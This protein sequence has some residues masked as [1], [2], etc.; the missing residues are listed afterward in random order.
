MQDGAPGDL[1]RVGL[2][3]GQAATGAAMETGDQ[4][5]LDRMDFLLQNKFERISCS[6]K[7]ISR[8]NDLA[9][10]AAPQLALLDEEAV[11]ALHAGCRVGH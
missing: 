6:P 5:G 1:L 7:Q 11:P 10:P 8:R 4:C 9:R 3:R 2:L